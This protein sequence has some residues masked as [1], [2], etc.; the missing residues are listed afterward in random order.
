MP[1]CRIL[2]VASRDATNFP[3]VLRAHHGDRLG[4]D[5][6]YDPDLFDAATA[7]ALADR[8][9]LLLA[10]IAADRTG[11]C[12]NWRGRPPRSAGGCWWTGT[13][14]STGGPSRP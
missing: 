6:A 13:A 14:A 12:A 10:E 5:L 11:R 1:G 4:F 7:D 3:L 8:L 2:D 9:C